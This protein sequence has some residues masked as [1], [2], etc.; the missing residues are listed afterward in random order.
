MGGTQELHGAGNILAPR[1]PFLDDQQRGLDVRCEGEH[2]RGGQQRWKV[3]NDD[4]GRIAALELFHQPGHLAP[5]EHFRGIQLRFAARKYNEPSDAGVA[6]AVPRW[7][8]P[9]RGNRSIR[10][11]ASNPKC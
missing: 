4:A 1:L 11:P 7:A 8:Y 5:T 3:E 9:R 10:A 2:V 6:S